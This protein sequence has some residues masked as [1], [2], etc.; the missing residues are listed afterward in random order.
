MSPR[1]LTWLAVLAVALAGVV[2][3]AIAE[4]ARGPSPAVFPPQ[5][6]TVRFDHR[7]HLS[8][9]VG[10]SCKTCHKAA[11][12]S[13]SVADRLTPEAKVCDDCHESDHA[14]LSQ[15]KP[16][17]GARGQCATC[18]LG[19]RAEDGNRV[20][21]M[22]LPRANMVF[23]HKKH[24]DRNIGCPKCHGEVKDVELATREQ[25]PRMQGCLGCHQRPDAASQG[26]AK[27]N[28]ET[29][30]V[31]GTGSEAGRIRTRFASGVLEPP[32]WLKNAAHT[33]DWIMRHKAVAGNDSAFCGNCHSERSCTD[34]HDGRV[35][36]RSVHPSDYLSMH[37]IE[38]R[39]ATQKCGSCHREQSFCLTCHQRMGVSM[40]GPPAVRMSS[41]FHPPKSLWSDAPKRPGHHAFEA[42]R[43]LDACVS[44]HIE[45]DCTSCH[46]ALGIGAGFN[47][48][49]SGFV[50]GCATQFR[51]NPRPCL[52][53]HEPSAGALDRCR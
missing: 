53:C 42:Q 23:N 31:R 43:N 33:P 32:A 44:C 18:H 45:R 40:S 25:L 14:D 13:Q 17:D 37:P 8:P 30:H 12:T 10:A 3:P 39:Q 26:D 36:P 47:P 1:L 51:R 50:G 11:L 16:G 7:K 22:I 20:A 5:T 27:G 34:C 35:R 4:P 6:L 24:A 49:R 21:R 38:A 52:I 41:R 28:C 15:V 46:G 9:A 2:A 19:Y 48:H 29:C